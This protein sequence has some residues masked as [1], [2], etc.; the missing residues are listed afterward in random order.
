M[1]LESGD[2]TIKKVTTEQLDI[3]SKFGNVSIDEAVVAGAFTGEAE[4][5]D[6]V[7]GTAEAE[8]L[9]LK[10]QF[11]GIDGNHI[12]A[13]DMILA[14]DSGDCTIDELSAKT[15]KATSSFGGISLGMLESVDSY[16]VDV[17]SE[18]GEVSVNYEDM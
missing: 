18:F 8:N 15:I 1:D 14:L 6:I 17:T 12:T 13:D 5:G 3:K 10:T 2:V 7:V 4:S 11:G 9:N 16:S